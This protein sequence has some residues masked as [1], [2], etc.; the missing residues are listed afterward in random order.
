[1]LDS[2]ADVSLVPRRFGRSGYPLTKPDVMLQD[3]QG[4]QVNVSG[5]RRIELALLGAES[6]VQCNIGESFVVAGVANI[7]VSLGRLMKMGWTVQ[8][9]E[10]PGEAGKLVT[11]DGSVDVP[12]YFRR[13]SLVVR[14]NVMSVQELSKAVVR[15]VQVD[16]GFSTISMEP[17]RGRWNFLDNGTPCMFS[18]GNA[19]L[20]PPGDGRTNMWKY[21]T[22]AVRREGG[23]C[24]IEIGADLS[25][26]VNREERLPGGYEGDMLTFVHR[27]ERSE[28]EFLEEAMMRKSNEGIVFGFESGVPEELRQKREDDFVFPAAGGHGTKS[29]S[30]VVDGKEVSEN[31]SIRELKRSCEFYG[32]S[33]SGTKQIL[34]ERICNYLSRRVEDDSSELAAKM[35]QQMVTP[36]VR[37]RLDV[38]QPTDREIRDH[39][40]THLPFQDWCSVCVRTKSREDYM[41]RIPKQEKEDTGKPHIQMD[42]MYMGQHCVSLVMM[43]SWA[44]MGKVVPVSSKSASKR[45]A[46]E[47]VRFSLFLNY[48]E[49]EVVFVMDQEPATVS[50]LNLVVATRQ[51]LG[52]KC[53]QVLGK[54]YDK[55]RTAR[56]E[57]FIQTVRNQA[58][59][60]VAALEENMQGTIPGEHAIRAW[61]LCHAAWLL[62]R[63]HVHSAL[64]ATPYETLMGKM[65]PGVIAQFGEYSKR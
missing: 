55:S 16:V 11:P 2:G 20:L 58:L 12:V 22:T 47:A 24:A 32:L 49:E 3:A 19:F 1:M 26:M 62:N 18:S 5:M 10:I 54:A 25:S 38:R 50:L 27:R 56:V 36:E 15:S 23:W 52:R 59:A 57:R 53:S 13:N 14:A 37:Q 8:Q 41:G 64:M 17:K 28:E 63:Y 4:A 44:R 21:R 60:L 46:E 40:A 51:R 35:R 42:F 29:E 30:V 45:L 43:D 65:Y 6:E 31:S 61:A 33:K 7:L 48:L 34:Y 9:S 39:A